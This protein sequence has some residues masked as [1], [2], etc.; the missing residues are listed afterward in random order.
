MDKVFDTARPITVCLS[1]G[2]SAKVGFP[3]DEQWIE[4]MKA[5][6]AAIATERAP[7]IGRVVRSLFAEMRN[8]SD[9]DCCVIWGAFIHPSNSTIRNASDRT[10]EITLQAGKHELIHVLY[11]PAAV[12][13][14]AVAKAFLRKDY[15]RMGGCYDRLTSS[16]SGYA[17]AVPLSHKVVV[18]DALMR[19]YEAE[20]GR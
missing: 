11:R 3:T 7:V 18:I 2:D 5:V 19:E 14:D 1:S 10:F 13:R 4:F 8:V 12:E 6:S 9:V 17:A 20:H 16:V 15:R